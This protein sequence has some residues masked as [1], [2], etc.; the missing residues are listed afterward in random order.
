[1]TKR[2]TPS[3]YQIA[4]LVD[5]SAPDSNDSVGAMFLRELW[6]AAVDVSEGQERNEAVDAVVPIYTHRGWKIFVDLTLYHFD[7]ELWADGDLVDV[8]GK[9]LWEFADQA[10]ATIVDSITE[11]EDTEEDE[12]DEDL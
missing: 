6:E 1:M 10:I 3:V 2:D 11:D 8:A 5:C 9:V 4:E 7:S 12:D